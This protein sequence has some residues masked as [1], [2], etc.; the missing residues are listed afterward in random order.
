MLLFNEISVIIIKILN[1]VASVLLF[2]SDTVRVVAE[3]ISRGADGH[4][5]K[6]SAFP[7]DITERRCIIIP[8]QRIAECIIGDSMPGVG[9]HLILEAA[10][11]V[12]ASLGRCCSAECTRC[13][14]VRLLVQYVSVAI[15]CPCVG[16]VGVGVIFANKR[17]KTGSPD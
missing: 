16:L 17:F 15:V 13:V 10:C 11:A 7:G 12:G 1:N 2:G 5:G 8:I 4:S 9:D 6:L 14:G 3:R